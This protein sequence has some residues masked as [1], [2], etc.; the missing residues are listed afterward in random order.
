M[1]DT[2]TD[3]NDKKPDAS[4][5][6]KGFDRARPILFGPENFFLKVNPESGDVWIVHDIP[7]DLDLTEATFDRARGEINFITASGE[8]FTIG[9]QPP[10]KLHEPLAQAE[11]LTFIYIP[12]EELENMI[13]IP[14]RQIS[15]K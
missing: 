1:T 14:L 5:L 11:R 6:G 2:P 3:K 9:Q 8:S 7:L 4:K 15:E 13:F 10:E 12:N